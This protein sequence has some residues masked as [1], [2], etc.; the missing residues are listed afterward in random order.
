MKRL[1][2]SE[3]LEEITE[4]KEFY[5]GDILIETGAGD[6]SRFLAK[7]CEKYKIQFHSFDISRRKI[8]GA[9]PVA[10]HEGNS[11]ETLKEFTQNNKKE[12]KFV[13]L[14]SAGS[15]W[16][17][18]LE[19]RTLEPY[20]KPGTTVVID[21]AVIYAGEITHAKEI[22]T[23][24]RKG[25]V[26]VPYFQASPFWAVKFHPSYGDT[27]VE[28]VLEDEIKDENYDEGMNNTHDYNIGIMR[29][30]FKNYKDCII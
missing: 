18:F 26:L 24:V 9:E 22:L 1:S 7:F 30:N 17:T 6:S 13:F 8:A 2:H 21:N 27:M 25:K 29:Q 20:L 23:E 11:L 12:I 4:R 10:F 14:D 28:A 3:A 19:F 5:E 16:H 15:A